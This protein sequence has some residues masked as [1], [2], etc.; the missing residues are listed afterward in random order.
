[1]VE[2]ERRGLRLASVPVTMEL[3]YTIAMASP[4]HLAVLADIELAAATMLQGHAPASVLEET[5]P[6]AKLVHAQQEERLWV[7]LFKDIPV[8]FA[9][10]EMLA[11]DLPHLQEM[12]VTPDHGHRGLGTALLHTVLDWVARS[13]YQKM[14]L[15]TFRNVPWNMPFYSRQGFVEIHAHEL[16]PELEAIVQDEASRGMD[17][18]QRVV[19]GYWL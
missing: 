16:R 11:E 15:T 2:N 18:A 4:E 8:G 13:G 19:M 10:V 1:M 12:D 6:R 9:L 17:R 14:T 7:A 3:D 5:I